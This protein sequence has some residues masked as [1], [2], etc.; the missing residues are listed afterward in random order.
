[1]EKKTILNKENSIQ[2]FEGDNRSLPTLFLLLVLLISLPSLPIIKI[3]GLYQPIRLDFILMTSFLFLFIA[4]S[5]FLGK[6]KINI[7]LLVLFIFTSLIYL[8]TSSSLIVATVQLIGYA[9]II[10][11]YI[12]VIETIEK[13]HFKLVA[14][15]F[16][17]MILIQIFIHFLGVLE[18]N[19]EITVG[20]ATYRLFGKYGTFGMP[21]KFGLF[22]LVSAIISPAFGKKQPI[23][24]ILIILAILTSDS[25]ISMI[26][27]FLYLFLVMPKWLPIL[28]IISILSV[29]F[30]SSAAKFLSMF[31]YMNAGLA[32]ILE[33]GSM[34]M[35][36]INFERYLDW[37]DIEKFIFGGGALSFLEYGTGYGQQ[38]PLDIAFL[39]L[40]TEFGLIISVIIL[41]L[42]F[43]LLSAM[44]KNNIEFFAILLA[45]ITYSIFNEGIMALRSGHYFFAVAALAV[46]LNKKSIKKRK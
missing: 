4:K 44:S 32:A 7:F 14:K 23:I 42:M 34:V 30:L 41:L 5:I 12:I 39:R 19:Y 31:S 46:Y 21:F 2:V 25:R 35:R 20:G 37:V 8:T 22:C 17:W 16:L 15:Y 24:L 13:K 29:T 36:R 43:R 9:S 18:I 26:S 40:L 3:P 27:F 1:M 38:G 33:E 28:A 10:L 6:I 45:I 11:S